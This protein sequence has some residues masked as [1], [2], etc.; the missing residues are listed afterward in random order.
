MSILLV[1]SNEQTH[2]SETDSQVDL[3]LI[4]TSDRSSLTQVSLNLSGDKDELV[5]HTSEN[6]KKLEIFQLKYFTHFGF[7]MRN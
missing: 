1:V 5:S 3:S 2:L 6:C 4:S 7:Q